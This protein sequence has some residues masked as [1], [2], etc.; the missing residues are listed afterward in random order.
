MANPNN[1]GG[2]V[3]RLAQDPTVFIN[4]DKSKTVLITLAVD[5]NFVS[6]ADRK[7]KSQFIEIRAF[8]PASVEGNGSWDRTH[9]GDLVSVATRLASRP[10]TD[11]DGNTVYPPVTV[12]ADGYPSFLESKKTVDERAAR[13]AVEATPAAE[14]P[15]SETEAQELARLRAQQTADATTPFADVPVAA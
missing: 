12:E 1:F 11:K 5:D 6:G 7:V 4:S 14:A 9:K 3:G 2:L 15:L 10:Y 13:R 8:V